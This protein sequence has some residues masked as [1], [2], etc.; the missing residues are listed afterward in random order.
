MRGR[1]MN[2]LYSLKE[3]VHIAFLQGCA[4]GRYLSHQF[5]VRAC[6]EDHRILFR[7]S[8]Y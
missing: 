1:W 3:Q 4:K 6:A 2:T 5:F 7:G 8:N